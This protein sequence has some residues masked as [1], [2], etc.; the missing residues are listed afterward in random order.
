MTYALGRRTPKNAPALELGPLLTGA[1]PP[2]PVA[3]DHF[4]DATFGL[5]GNDQYGDCGPTSVAN[6]VR[7][8]S[9]ALTGTQV[10]P[11]QDD[12]FDLYRRSGNPN[13]DPTT[14]ADDNGVDMQTMLEA[15]LS[16]GIGDGSGGVIKPVAFAKVKV[17][18]DDELEAANAIFGG[19]LWGVT[20]ETAQQAQ[21]DAKPPVWDYKASGTWGGHAILNGKYNAQDEEVISWGLDVQTTEAFRQHQLEEAWVVIWQWNL[22]NP[23]F[24]AGVDVQKLADDYKA[25]T[26]KT[27]PVPTP[28]PTPQPTPDPTPPEPDPNPLPPAPGP[29]PPAP[30]PSEADL[31]LLDSVEDWAYVQHYYRRDRKVATAIRRWIAAKGF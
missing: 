15:L 14:D 20:L 8:V 31:E 19:T 23:A 28:A 24:L 25:L 1:L 10:T 30:E 22:D 6:L 3:V 5:Y 27:L 11:S 29:N 17:T 21:T 9:K 18:S 4:K 26:G 2:V 16:G 12:V 7:L 13:F